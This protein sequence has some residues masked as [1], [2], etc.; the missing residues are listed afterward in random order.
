MRKSLFLVRLQN[1]RETWEHVINYVGAARLGIGGVTG[2]WSARD[3]VAHVMVRE[4]YLADRL[5]ELQQGQTMLICQTQDELDTF[6]EDFGYP[7]FES[8]IINEQ[9]A[10]DWVVQK[11]RNTPF[12]DLVELEMRAYDDIFETLKMIPEEQMLAHKLFAR[13]SHYTIEHYR[14]YAADLIKRFKAPLKR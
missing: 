5:H 2:H 3:I 11:F 13:V 8:P 1:E 6:L 14:Q 9:H 4:Q 7:D 12:K 10:N